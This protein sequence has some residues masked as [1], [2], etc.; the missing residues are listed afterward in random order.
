MNNEIRPLEPE[1]EKFSASIHK[2]LSCVPKDVNDAIII[3][4]EVNQFRGKAVVAYRRGKNWT[5]AGALEKDKQ[6]GFGV[7][8][9]VMYA[10]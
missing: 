5:F 7:E 2:A 4:G 3:T 6:K 8:A 1:F 10:R 9:V